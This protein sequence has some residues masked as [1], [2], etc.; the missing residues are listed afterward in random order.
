MST[1][2]HSQL[3]DETIGAIVNARHGDPFSVL[4]MFVVNGEVVV[5]AMLPQASRV[6]VVDSADGSVV[7]ELPLISN[8][9][10]FAGPV[11]GR[12]TKFRYRL[13]VQL[14]TVVSDIEDPYRFGPILTD[15]DLYLFGEGN[16]R[17]LYDRFGAHQVTVDDV[18]GVS[19]VVWAPN[20]QRVSV[21][22]DFNAWDGRR[23]PMR[24]RTSGVLEI[25]IPDVPLGARYKYELIG[26]HGES[27]PLKAD[28][29]AFAGERPPATA[30]LV[31]LPGK[32]VWNDAE[33]L[34]TRQTANRRNAPISVYEVHLGS[35][36]RAEGNRYLTYGEL[37]D[38]LIPYVVDLGF[39][40]IELMPVSEHPFDGSWGYQPVG[41]FAPTSRFGTPAEF[42]EFVERAHD[43]G[44]GVII[45]WVPGH[46]PT[47]A[48]GL[49]YFDGTA[50]YE[51]AD[52]KEGFHQDWNTFIYTFG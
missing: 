15:L 16:H 11:S 42:A 36:Q 9:G 12:T 23:H 47:D 19:F 35:W 30:S 31:A 2:M 49:G 38:K 51:H 39:T 13:R 10:L 26:P 8:E 20:A 21:V 24:R 37:A 22:G 33:W 5:R 52:P 50:L 7:A 40:H 4:G 45:D 34:L 29:F 48:H 1:T 18:P 25:F 32:P 3:P 6:Q 46:F 17:Q 44:I 41:L 28:P 14:G 43:A 27:L